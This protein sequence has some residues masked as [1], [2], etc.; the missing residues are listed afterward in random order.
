M[1]SLR[2]MLVITIS[3]L[4]FLTTVTA[5]FANTSF[6]DLPS[7]HWATRH[8]T[9]MAEERIVSG[10]TENGQLV[11][12]PESPVSRVQAVHMIFRTLRA[13]NKLKSTENYV[14]KYR[15]VLASYNIPEWAYEATAYAWEY[16]ILEG[17]DLA[18]LMSGEQQVSASRQ[19]V[20]VYLGKAIDPNPQRSSVSPLTFIDREMIHASAMPYVELLVKNN[21]FSGDN[22]N[23]FNPQNTI[24]RAE[25]ATICSKAYD[26]LKTADIV[27]EVPAPVPAP[28]EEEPNIT[29][30]GGTLEHVVIANRTILVRDEEDVMDL[31]EVPSSA[32]IIIDGTSRSINA[33]A[34]GQRVNL[35][36]ENSNRLTKIEVNPK[37]NKIEGFIDRIMLGDLYHR[38]VVGG[39]TYRVYDDTE[40]KIEDKTAAFRDLKED[41]SVTIRYEGDRAIEVLVDYEYQSFTG[42]LNSGVN[43]GRYP[44]RIS[45]RTVGS[46]I[47]DLEIHD[48]VVVRRD[49]R[50]ADLEDLVRGDIVNIEV[51]SSKVR[52]I[53]ATG[54]DTKQEDKGTIKSITIENP[55]RLTITNNNDEEVTYIID[56]A[57]SVYLDNERADIYDLRTNYEVELELQN[58]RVIEIEAK[59]RGHRNIISGE[60]T[61]IHEGLNRMIV[62]PYDISSRE[63]TVTVYYNRHTKFVED[64]GREI[65]IRY[66]DRD[67]EV[68][69]HGNYENNEFVATRIIVL[70][71]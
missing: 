37:E 27:V 48:D 58:D 24:T 55:I 25:M 70:M 62:R 38:I 41:D 22:T 21:I 16:N 36:F 67:D 8:I 63:E 64:T 56:N 50:S 61:R 32:E 26:V 23:R 15:N 10:M 66:L 35:T 46:E 45:V 34:K 7:S 68:I 30:K 44:F 54:I 40:I 29:K 51:R 59:R 28:V 4:M 71:D 65:D 20:A 13:T 69:I 31:Y 1:K 17:N 5:S 52:R 18:N 57:V 12:K 3:L 49:N 42:I 43:F 60:I 33:L 11:F 53:E 39:R 6:A 19:Q 2:K 14:D 9:K 47:R